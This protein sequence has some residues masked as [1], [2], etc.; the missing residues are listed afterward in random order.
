MHKYKTHVKYKGRFGQREKTE[1]IL[2][3]LISGVFS[4][5][6]APVTIA[7]GGP[8]GT[9]KSTFSAK[10]S[11]LL[12]DSAILRL[13]DYKTARQVRKEQNVFGA[14]PDANEMNLAAEHI[15]LIK[16]NTAFDKPV[17]N[18]VTGCADKTERFEPRRFN[19][20]DGEISTYRDFRDDVDFSIFIDAHYMT[21]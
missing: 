10:L 18:N 8:G 17:Y 13:D 20:L 1:D 3:R 6:I 4:S 19:I 12:A 5:G 7:V 14:H 16:K 2:A 21:K 11:A 9:G 15:S